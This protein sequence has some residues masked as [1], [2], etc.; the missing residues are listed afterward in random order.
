M[1]QVASLCQPLLLAPCSRPSLSTKQVGFPRRDPVKLAEAL[2][3]THKVLWIRCIKQS[4]WAK[5]G[6]LLGFARATGDRALSAT[7]RHV[8]VSLAVQQNHSKVLI[9]HPGFCPQQAHQQ[10]SPVCQHTLQDRLCGGR[11][12]GEKR[13][14]RHGAD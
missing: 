4:R 2:H 6:Q 9:L 5:L 13:V 14:S 7:I 10:S 12:N 1:L 11:Q 3:H 8:A